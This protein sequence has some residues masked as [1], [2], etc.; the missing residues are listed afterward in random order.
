MCKEEY[1]QIATAG[2]TSSRIVVLLHNWTC[3]EID[4]PMSKDFKF[5]HFQSVVQLPLPLLPPALDY[6]HTFGIDPYTHLCICNS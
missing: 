2:N 4:T 3:D 5:L 6:M 1:C